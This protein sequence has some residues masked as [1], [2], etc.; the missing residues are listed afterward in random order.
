MFQLVESVKLMLPPLSLSPG[1]FWNF[2]C[3]CK[4]FPQYRL[5]WCIERVAV[6]GL[7]RTMVGEGVGEFVAQLVVQLYSDIVW[8]GEVGIVILVFLIL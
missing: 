1:I 7:Y 3:A 5:V 6:L 8:Y 2:G 4:F